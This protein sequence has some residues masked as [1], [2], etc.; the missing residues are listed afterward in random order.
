MVKPTT[1]GTPVAPHGGPVSLV[2]FF[3]KI[4][5]FSLPAGA[6]LQAQRKLSIA[7][8]PS[9]SPGLSDPTYRDPLSENT[10]SVDALLPREPAGQ[11]SP[12][13]ATATFA[14]VPR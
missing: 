14:S 10:E 9:A 11:Q 13:A 6:E 4:H 2:H 8:A 1:Y 3:N 5:K 7:Q 12:R